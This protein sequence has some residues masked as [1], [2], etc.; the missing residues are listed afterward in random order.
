[1]STSHSTSPDKAPVVSLDLEF[2]ARQFRISGG[3]IR[4]ATLTAAFLAASQDSRIEMKHVV[5]GLQRELEKLGRLINAEDFGKYHSL[6][7]ENQ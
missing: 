5:H 4:N 2:L 3:N 7:W 6:T 1:M